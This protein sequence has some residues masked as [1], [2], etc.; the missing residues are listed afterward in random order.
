MNILQEKKGKKK[1][2]GEHKA[3]SP[4]NL[5]AFLFGVFCYNLENEMPSGKKRREQQE[6]ERQ[7]PI[8]FVRRV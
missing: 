5:S 6:F 4:A 7:Q 3:S 8:L 1:R 2:T